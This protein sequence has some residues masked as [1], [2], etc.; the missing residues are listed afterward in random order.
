MVA[1]FS[2]NLADAAKLHLSFLQDAHR[3]G[4]T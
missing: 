2:V 3:E 1:M 4:I